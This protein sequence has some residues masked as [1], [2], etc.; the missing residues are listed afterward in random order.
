MW[1][2]VFSSAPHLLHM[3][4]SISFIMYRCLLRVL[5]PVRRPVTTLDWIILKNTSLDLAAG[6]GLEINS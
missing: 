4:L 3:G 1:A 6:L 2:E 5:H